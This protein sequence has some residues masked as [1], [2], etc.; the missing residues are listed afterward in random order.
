MNKFNTLHNI[1][2]TKLYKS[3]NQGDVLVRYQIVGNPNIIR[4]RMTENSELCNYYR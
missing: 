1:H 4:Q 2:Y 3:K